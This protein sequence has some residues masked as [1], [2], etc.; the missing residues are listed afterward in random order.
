MMTWQNSGAFW[1]CSMA[2]GIVSQSVSQ[3][4]SPLL[5]NLK[6]LL[7]IRWIFMLET[8]NPNDVGVN[9]SMVTHNDERGTHCNCSTLLP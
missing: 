6:Y 9:V 4:V 8:M 2:L 1:H 5:S 7:A 3:S